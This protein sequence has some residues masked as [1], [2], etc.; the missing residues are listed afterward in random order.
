MLGSLFVTRNSTSEN[1]KLRYLQL[2][3]LL[4]VKKRDFGVVATL[5]GDF[6]NRRG[7]NF[8]SLNLSR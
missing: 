3:S 1:L 4:C 8:S 7:S 6:L 2:Q 5:R